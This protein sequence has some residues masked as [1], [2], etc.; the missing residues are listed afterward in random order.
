[1]QSSR[2]TGAVA[3]PPAITLKR[4][5]LLG[6]PGAGKGT[7]A[8]WLGTAIQAAHISTGDLIRQAIADG[9]PLG[10]T[11]KQYSDRGELV[12]DKVIVDLVLPYL[13]SDKGWILDGFPRDVAQAQ[14]LSTALAGLG[15]HLD[16]VIALEIPD[17]VLVERLQ[18][19]RV[20]AATGRTYNLHLDPPAAD[21]PGP[22]TQRTDDHPDEIRRRLQVYH[23]K[24]EPLLQYYSGTGLLRRVPAGEAI[25]AVHNLI[26]AA[27]VG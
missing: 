1:M 2:H 4:L 27:L 14:A 7:Q 22:F 6:P 15:Q 20:S 21:D 8:S 13:T 26:L 3:S 10:R 9:T 11:V 16:R 24:T 23:E 12:P 19:R 17:E 18:F 5:V 25:E